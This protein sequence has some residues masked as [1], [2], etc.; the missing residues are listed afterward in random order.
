MSRKIITEIIFFVYFLLFVTGNA[1]AA[2]ESSLI[3]EVNGDSTIK[4][5]A[6]EHKEKNKHKEFDKHR[7]YDKHEHDKHDKYSKHE[8]ERHRKHKKNNN[9]RPTLGLFM[10]DK[11]GELK[12]NQT[13]TP[14]EKPF[15]I[16][17][18]CC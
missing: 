2:L 16:H 10:I 14:Q 9:L 11:S 3:K 15:S 12:E 6:D 13:F 7:K 4:Y 18:V 5:R 1:F 17:S 8:H